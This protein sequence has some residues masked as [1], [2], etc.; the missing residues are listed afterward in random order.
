MDLLYVLILIVFFGLTVACVFA[1]A[2]LERR[3][4]D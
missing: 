1:C 2:A 3:S 4:H